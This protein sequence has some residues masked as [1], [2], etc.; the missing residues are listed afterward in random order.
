[1]FPILY[2]QITAGVV[3]EHNGLG[4]L[5]DCSMCESEQVGNDRYE[6]V[7]EYS[8]NGI[9]A[10]EIASRRVIKIK[11]NPTDPP[12]LFRIK[13]IGKTMNG[14][15]SVYC[16][17]ISYDLSG[18]EITSGT[19]NSAEATC[20]LLQGS[21][22]GY[23]IDTDK[24]V[25]AE[26]KVDTPASVRSYFA[27]KAGSFL[28]VYGTA[29]IKYDNFHVSF[30]LHAGANRGVQIRYAK[31]LLE[32]SQEIDC[33]NLYTHVLCYWKKEDVKVVGTKVAT[34]LTLDVP[35]TLV[36]DCSDKFE[37]EPTVADL[38]AKA[39]DYISNHNLTTPTNNIKL[40]YVQSGEL[41][42]RVDLFD[43]VSIYYEA[44]GIERAGAKCIRTK[45]DCLREKYIEVEFGDVKTDITDTIAVTN[46]E[47]A[48]KPSTTAMEQAIN[49][50]VN[51]ITGNSGG[52]VV[53]H[54][55]NNDGEPDEI[56]IMDAP[57]IENAVNIWRWNSAGL[58]HSSQGY[59]PARFDVAITYD[60]H[61][62]ADYIDTGTLS[63]NL[64]KAGVLSDLAGNSQIDM[65]NGQAIL[66]E[67][68]AKAYSRVI[69]A[70]TNDVLAQ[71]VAGSSGGNFQLYNRN[72][73]LGVYINAIADGGNLYLYDPSGNAR[74]HFWIGSQHGD[75]IINLM[76]SNGNVTVELV[77]E[78]GRL[79]AKNAFEEVYSGTLSNVGAWWTFLT[80][81]AGLLIV[82]KVRASG[83]R[84]TT[85]IP[86]K[87][88]DST[89]VRYYL[90]DET[91]YISF[92]ASIVD[93]LVKV[94][95]AAKSSDGFIE[96]VY[97]MF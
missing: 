48:E 29:E 4:I 9:H 13:R 84:S 31:N 50:A 65:T 86:V 26:F 8:M 5:S 56:L 18:C 32:L 74:A 64:I 43:T 70:D 96:K 15:F 34:G 17:H 55:A 81:F 80:D 1:M 92:N 59:D 45:Y 39:T 61:I 3:P 33:D 27:G 68:A 52:Y 46:K 72:N 24:Q 57:K 82:G 49:Y 63:A 53:M 36:V 14:K 47:V 54:D 85:I 62:V 30:L 69:D 91:N 97:G 93:G 67:L 11:T 66:Y 20:L 37:T 16:R 2:E 58:A 41:T 94:E 21:A 76:D 44:L 71:M 79:R 35:N 60:G 28:D 7:F 95:I 23:T 10:K 90:S 87:M 6:V 51:L 78:D 88:L 75:G 42:E 40:D 89:P 12:Q 25:S 83:S 22:S 73:K 77:G 19:A 38:T